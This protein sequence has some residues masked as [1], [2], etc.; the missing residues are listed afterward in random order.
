MNEKER[1]L[2]EFQNIFFGNAYFGKSLFEQL[3][4]LSLW[5]VFASPISQSHNI[6]E[7]TSHILFWLKDIN[8]KM[9]GEKI[10][11]DES[12]N[13]ITNY[14]RDEIEWKKLLSEIK[15][16]SQEIKKKISNFSDSDFEKQIAEYSNYTLIIGAIT[17]MVYHLGEISILKKANKK[18]GEVSVIDAIETGNIKK[19]DEFLKNDKSIVTSKYAYD[20]TLLHFAIEFG[21]I[22]IVKL[23]LEYNFDIEAKTSF[24]S[25]PI[26]WA[27]TNSFFEIA[28]LLLE[29]NAD[30]GL[31]ELSG[32]GKIDLVKKYYAE[33]LDI[34]QNEIS[35]AFVISCRN[36]FLNVAEFLLRK[37]A[38]INFKS[39][40]GATALH[41]T[42]LNGRL[43]IVKFLLK[44][45]AD[46]KIEDDEF[47]LTPNFWAKQN[48]HFEVEKLLE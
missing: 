1:I 24:N 30:V 8:S 20:K 45:G 32:M 9:N 37:H 10:K 23:L 44:N 40:L 19:V 41:F 21:K 12:K 31:W 38:D 39:E 43:E 46:K 27:I 7:I 48:G 35:N 6:F 3:E 5:Q 36:N 33:N 34:S 29:K 15:F 47:K 11:F 14:N 13:W 2:N 42:A 25:T 26:Q 28:E 22:K 17:H 4:E 16:V 18:F